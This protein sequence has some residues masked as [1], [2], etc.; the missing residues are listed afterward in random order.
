[1]NGISQI[2]PTDGA[3][4]A[5]ETKRSAGAAAA[6]FSSV[7][8]QSLAASEESSSVQSDSSESVSAAQE[9]SS[10]AS[11]TTD[12]ITG[13]ITGQT[14]VGA[15]EELATDAAKSATD[16]GD[17]SEAMKALFLFCMMMQLG[18]GL[19]GASGS[20]S[21]GSSSGIMMLM[22]AMLGQFSKN[23]EALYNN[24]VDPTYNAD[25]L[26]T[27]AEVFERAGYT[28][29]DV[30]NT[31]GTGS[32]ILP[33]QFWQPTTPAL[34]NSESN[35][36]AENLRAVIDQFNVET[37]ERYRPYRD[38]YTYCNI[39][40]WDVT[41]A[42]GAEIPHYIDS[43]TG[44]IRIYPDTS[45]TTP[46]D[47]AGIERWLAG[48]GAGY[49]WREV[50]A[51]E[52]QAAANAG[53]PAVTTAGS[54]GHVQVVCPSENASFDPVRG[55][56]VAQA[57]SKVYNYTYISNIYGAATLNSRIRYWVHE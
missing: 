26:D 5:G 47:A 34:T 35:R 40:V 20:G 39:F 32:A 12:L 11:D 9:P 30:P 46:L 53:K 48:Y 56:T 13:L 18:G 28:K 22:T 41:S 37:A 50:S 42:M 17:M 49:G 3:R 45:G 6:D 29:T 15:L 55:V 24:A 25:T 2:N 51:Q 14:D 1:M 54:I 4:T 10:A 8:Q 19:G 21:S 33:T 31:T 43:K 27:V 7:L 44:E 52:A 23:K 38:G 16:S 57:G 36:S